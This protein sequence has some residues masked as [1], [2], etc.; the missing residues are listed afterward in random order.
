MQSFDE[1]VQ[2]IGEPGDWHEAADEIK[3][4]HGR[5]ASRWLADRLGVSLRQAQRYLKGD[6][7]VP[8]ATR[9]ASIVEGVDRS[10][11]AAR[12]IRTA[13][14]L[15]IGSIEMATSSG[16]TK[17]NVGDMPVTPG[18]RGNLNAAADAL[19]AG[20]VDQAGALFGSAVLD[21]YFS[22]GNAGGRHKQNDMG[23]TGYGDGAY[24]LG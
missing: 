17:R 5:G 10:K 1:F 11:A 23:V 16:T 3:S 4:Q 24:V 8:P 20:D 13:T 7:R 19:E 9:Q 15:S 12:H 14:R 22:K 18:M 6:V 2:R 21:S